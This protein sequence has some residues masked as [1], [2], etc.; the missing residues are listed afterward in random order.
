MAANIQHK[1]D[2]HVKEGLLH[3]KMGVKPG[4]KIPLAAL[5]KKKAEAKKTHN[6]KLEEETTF[7][8]NARKFKH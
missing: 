3:Q 8:I 1:V 7:A 4:A 5:E 2:I 6:T